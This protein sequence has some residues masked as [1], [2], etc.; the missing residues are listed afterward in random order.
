MIILAFAALVI[1]VLGGACAWL[2]NKVVQVEK[3]VNVNL[4]LSCDYKNDVSRLQTQMDEMNEQVANLIGMAMSE[5]PE[6]S[7]I[8]MFCDPLNSDSCPLPRRE[9]D[10]GLL[11][12][13]PAEPEDTP[14][15]GDPPVAEEGI[16]ASGESSSPSSS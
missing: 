1:L 8:M 14:I 2:Y 7:S 13:L 6:P 16:E 5:D 9:K 4:G 3:R 11:G 12:E 10:G 15:L